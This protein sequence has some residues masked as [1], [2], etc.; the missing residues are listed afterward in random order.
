[1]GEIV[2]AVDS[3]VAI[4][5]VELQRPGAKFMYPDES[6][7]EQLR[8]GKYLTS[9]AMQTLKDEGIGLAQVEDAIR[10]TFLKIALPFSPHKSTNVRNAEMA[11]ILGRCLPAG[12]TESM[13][14][15]TTVSTVDAHIGVGAKGSLLSVGTNAT[16]VVDSCP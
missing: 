5:P 3:G 7:Y 4:L 14:A 12:R 8:C 11:D 16:T 10:Q 2:T 9:A 15:G 6:F 13:P 1:M